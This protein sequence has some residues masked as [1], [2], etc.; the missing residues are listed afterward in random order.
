MEAFIA[1][2][3]RAKVQVIGYDTDATGTLSRDWKVEGI[4]MHIGISPAGE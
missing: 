3:V 2:E 1:K 4:S